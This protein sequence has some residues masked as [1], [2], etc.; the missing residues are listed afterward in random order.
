MINRNL[1]RMQMSRRQLQLPITNLI[2]TDKELLIWQ[3]IQ[4]YKYYIKESKQTSTVNRMYSR[5]DMF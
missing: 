4:K 3:R 1:N 5:E 2:H